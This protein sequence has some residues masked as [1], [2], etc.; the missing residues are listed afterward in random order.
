MDYKD[1]IQ[2][3]SEFLKVFDSRKS[4]K[5]RRTEL[6]IYRPLFG[7]T[8]GGFRRQWGWELVG[9][10]RQA[11]KG[12]ATIVNVFPDAPNYIKSLEGKTCKNFLVLQ[13]EI[14]CE[15][16]RHEAKEVFRKYLSAEM[17]Q[18]KEAD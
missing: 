13:N 12:P 7:N 2:D 1:I 5:T 14:R 9:E 18:L 16:F 17:E 11:G 4:Y 15:A 8:S 3:L 6:K 10:I